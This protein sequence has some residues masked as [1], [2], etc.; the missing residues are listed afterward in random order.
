MGWRGGLGLD[1]PSLSRLFLKKNTTAI[2]G[3]HMGWPVSGLGGFYPRVGASQIVR[4]GLTQM[5]NFKTLQVSVL[6]YFIWNKVGEL[7]N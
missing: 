5:D 4:S 6:F 3:W 1:G 7:D 2:R